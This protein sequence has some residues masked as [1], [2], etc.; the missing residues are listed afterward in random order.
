MIRRTV[1]DKTRIIHRGKSDKPTPKALCKLRHLCFY[2]KSDEER[3][4][5]LPSGRRGGERLTI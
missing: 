2:E 3:L 5:S 1:S 4:R